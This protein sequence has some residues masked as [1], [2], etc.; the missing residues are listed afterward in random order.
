MSS[1]DNF[2]HFFNAAGM[3]RDQL[4]R[5][6]SAGYVPQEKQVLFHAACNLADE[7][8]NPNEIAYGGALGGGKTHSAF[9]Q[10][11]ID[12]CQRFDDL[13]VLFLRKVGKYARESVEDLRRSIL[14]KVKHDFTSGIIHFS[15]QSRI[16]IGAFQYENDID[17]YLSLEY[18]IILIEQAEQISGK[19]IELIKTRNRSSK[20]F[21]P[22]MYFT[23]NWGGVSHTFLKKRFYLPYKTKKETSTKFIPATAKDNKCLDE[24]YY[25]TTLKPLTGWRREAW[26]E[27][28][29]DVVAGT[30]FENF[31]Q[32]R[33]VIS[34]RK[35]P[36][37][38]KPF[39]VW[40]SMDFGHNHYNVTYL[41]TK[42]DGMVYVV[43]ET[44]ARK[45]LVATN[46]KD[47]K[48]MLTRWG[49]TVNDLATFVTGTDT[50]AKRGD[51][52][53]SP[54]DAFAENKIYLRPAK[55]NRIAGAGKFL[56]M[57]GDEKQKIEP[58]IR[59]TDR[60]AGLIEGIPTLVHDPNRPE[61]VLKVDIDEDG[62]G[63]DD[64]Y[65]AA[66]YGVME[67]DISKE[68]IF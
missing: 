27:G 29:P 51:T 57:F 61:D 44:S 41:F 20:G 17:N 11:A 3:K 45:Q 18:D 66:R 35:L 47:I 8:Q 10:I 48:E 62:N 16:I 37:D 68:V 52:G 42:I 38:L 58:T 12:D 15:N 28:N 9:T 43:D 59:I 65:D 13:K 46:A 31:N 34:Y 56:E 60:C 5:F 50:F 53:K 22:R 1:L 30:F 14:K 33:L 21:R 64:Y 67:S 23:F 6:L 39:L 63:Y 24:E 4:E 19:K 26:V 49:L 2:L 54:A 25:N 32:D 55:T 36:V 7:I 40:C